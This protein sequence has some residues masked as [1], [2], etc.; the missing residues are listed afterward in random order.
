MRRSPAPKTGGDPT[1][2]HVAA[3][4]A[5]RRAVFES[6]G[7]TE[8]AVRAAAGTGG[9]LPGPGGLVRHSGAGTSRIASPTPTWPG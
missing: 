2:R 8:P 4:N 5:L 3:V 1:N 7:S 6:P 9:E